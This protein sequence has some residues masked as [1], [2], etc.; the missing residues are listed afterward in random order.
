MIFAVEFLCQ[1]KNH[2]RWKVGLRRFS[3]VPSKSHV[4]S[5]ESPKSWTMLDISRSYCVLCDLVPEGEAVVVLR[6][7]GKI[8]RNFRLDFRL[9]LSQNGGRQ[10]SLGCSNVNPGWINSRLFISENYQIG[11]PLYHI[12]RIAGVFLYRIWSCVVLIFA[13]KSISI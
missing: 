11:A 6:Q 9:D 12:H 13:H 3:E 5:P 2:L 10:G 1:K 7:V 4:Q 8:L